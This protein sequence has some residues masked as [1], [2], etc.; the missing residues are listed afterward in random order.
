MKITNSLKIALKNLLSI[1]MGSVQTDKAVLVWDGDEDLKAG[2]EVFVLDENGEAVPA[3]DGD[4]TTEDGKTIKV[5]EGRVAEIV[6]P[7]AEVAEEPVEEEIQQEAQEEV[8]EV[9]QEEVQQEAN[10]EVEPAEDLEKPEEEEPSIEDRIAAIEERMDAFLDGMNQ[11][12][13][14]IAAI[15]DRVAAVEEKLAKVEEP[16]ADPIDEQPEV[17]ESKSIMNFLRKK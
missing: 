9:Q 8:D 16:A 12:M 5:A 10:E 15:E 4:Y 6:D 17:Q 7:E 3:A 13:N 1:K 2:D 11:I 14:A